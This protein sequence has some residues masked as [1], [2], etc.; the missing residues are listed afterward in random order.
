MHSSC[1][2]WPRVWPY[3]KP[4]HPR[5]LLTSC[6]ICK[7]ARRLG[8]SSS[9]PMDQQWEMWK[10]DFGVTSQGWANSMPQLALHMVSTQCRHH[11]EKGLRAHKHLL[12]SLWNPWS[13]TLSVT[14]PSTSGAKVVTLALCCFWPSILHE[15]RGWAPQLKDAL[16]TFIYQKRW[17]Y[18]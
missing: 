4:W 16:T 10:V 6:W 5:N 2:E 1:S 13:P 3:M 8:I 9:N 15:D 12:R 11:T 7:F 14:S 18:F 17:K